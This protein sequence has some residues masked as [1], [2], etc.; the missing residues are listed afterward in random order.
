MKG[1][2][3]PTF[4]EIHKRYKFTFEYFDFNIENEE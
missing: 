4:D 1:E 3:H 2:S